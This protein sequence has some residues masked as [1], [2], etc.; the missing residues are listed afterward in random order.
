M[1]AESTIS[2]NL[3]VNGGYTLFP[4]RGDATASGSVQIGTKINGQIQGLVLDNVK[5]TATDITSN[6]KNVDGKIEACVSTITD[7]VTN[8]FGLG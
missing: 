7:G 2:G 6:Y 1:G 8:Y 5:V 4:T 3:A